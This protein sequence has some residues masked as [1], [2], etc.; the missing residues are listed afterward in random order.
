MVEHF[1]AIEVISLTA[2]DRRL[3]ALLKGKGI[4]ESNDN[5]SEF[6][7]VGAEANF[8]AQ[9]RDWAQTFK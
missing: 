8:W 6:D 4:R 9:V 1:T 5:K 2:D 3:R 7:D